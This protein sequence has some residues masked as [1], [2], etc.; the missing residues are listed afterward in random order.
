[1]D[2]CADLGRA[3]LGDQIGPHPGAMVSAVRSAG[4]AVFVAMKRA[5]VVVDVQESFRQRPNW[6]ATSN[7]E[8]AKQVQR[9]ADTF[10]ARG[11]MI[12]WVLHVEPG[13]G[14]VFDPASG[15]VR[16]MDGLEAGEGESV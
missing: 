5:L 8:I 16:L 7:P 14:T 12:V 1:M 3:S 4:R 11:E 13:T 9:L 6:A 2:S 10:R 15:F